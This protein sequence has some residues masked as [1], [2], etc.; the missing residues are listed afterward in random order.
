MASSSLI[1]RILVGVVIA[2][3]SITCYKNLQNKETLKVARETFAA[4]DAKISVLNAD[5]SKTKAEAKKALAEMATFKS[6][7]DAM[8]IQ[9]ASSKAEADKLKQ[10]VETA[11]STV[12]SK[13]TE[14]ASFK[15]QIEE[16]SQP[17]PDPGPDPVMVEKV[18]VAE[19]K[20]AKAEQDVKAAIESKADAEKKLVVLEE[21]AKRR[22]DRTLRAG[23]EAKVLA[24]NPNWNFVVVSIGDKQGVMPGTPLIVKRGATMVAKLRVTSVEPSTSIADIQPAGGAKFGAIQPGD[25]VIFPSGS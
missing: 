14:I 20:A 21:D 6:T 12:R 2:L 22:T 8:D 13:E 24:V 15:K 5:I 9:L 23:L 4:K 25:I 1:P 19:A 17:K 18:T 3:S 10:D 11:N 7:K 16:L